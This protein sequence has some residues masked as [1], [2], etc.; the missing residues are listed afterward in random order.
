[1]IRETHRVLFI[2]PAAERG[3]GEVILLN[4]LRHFPTQNWHKEVVLLSHGSIAT[5]LRALGIRT[6]VIPA[7]RFRQPLHLIRAVWHIARLARIREVSLI[8][9][10]GAKGHIYG[11]LAALMTGVPAVWRIQDIS[12]SSNVWLRLAAI[13]P[14]AGLV[15]LSRETL[16]AY[17]RLHKLPK[18]VEIVYPGVDADTLLPKPTSDE[19]SLHEELHIPSNRHIV[20]VVGR[21]QKGKGQHIFLEAAATVLEHHRDAHF[22]IVGA[23]LFGI[24]TEYPDQLH[25]LV[26]KKRLSAH[27][28]FTGQRH[29]VGRIIAASDILVQP[30]LVQEAFGYAAVEGMFLGKAVIASASGG[31]LEIM[32][33]GVDGL[34]VPPG[35]VNALAHAILALLDDPARRDRLGQAAM[36]TVRERF[37]VERMAAEFIHFYERILSNGGNHSPKGT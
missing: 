27:V 11:G 32:S 18:V 21:L 17:E 29:D 33:D 34:L 4:L 5:E 36:L 35:D 19:L 30:S 9:S 26:E 31:P 23:A 7:G 1:M 2:N 10:A 37:T 20:T 24:E 3:G 8:D 15:A 22:L 25:Q 28:S 13:V 12:P 14:A 6:Y 16:D